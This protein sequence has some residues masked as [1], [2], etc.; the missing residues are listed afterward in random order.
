MNSKKYPIVIQ[1]FLIICILF[2]VVVVFTADWMFKIYAIVMFFVLLNS[3]T[4]SISNFHLGDYNDIYCILDM[5]EYASFAIMVLSAF[6]ENIPIFWLFSFIVQVLYIPWNA[7]YIKFSSLSPYNIR[8]IRQYSVLDGISASI[9]LIVF[10]VSIVT[11]VNPYYLLLGFASWLIVLGMWALDNFKFDSKLELP[12][13]KIVLYDARCNSW[14]TVKGIRVDKKGAIEEIKFGEVVAVP[15]ESTEYYMLPGLIDTHVHVDQNPYS[16]DISPLKDVYEIAVANAKEAAEAG[17]TTIVDM[18]GYQLNNYYITNKLMHANNEIS[19]IET[20]GCFFSKQYGHYMQHGGFVVATVSDASLYANYLAKLGIK[21]A[22]FMLGNYEIDDVALKNILKVG[23]TSDQR[24]NVILDEYFP[25]RPILS[26]DYDE[27]AF[28]KCID[29]LNS[30]KTYS[31]DELHSIVAEFKKKDIEVFAHAF[32][33]EDVIIA[34]EA[35]ITK[36]EHPGDYSDDLI[37]KMR[38]KN[39]IVTSSF[40]AAEDGAVLTAGLPQISVACSSELMDRWYQDTRKILPKLYD[41]GVKVAL[42]TDSGLSGTPCCSL[43]REI[44]SLVEELHIPPQKVIKSATI[45]A[46][47]KINANHGKH[48][49]ELVPKAPADFVLYESNFINNI[50]TLRHPAQVWIRGEKV[51]EKRYD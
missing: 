46:A 51:F 42:G 39:V 2:D 7:I 45:I 15:D 21:F 32:L 23:N 43:I 49:G 44:I 9:S 14:K 4:N 10:I 17:I 25:K 34:I 27:D 26:D 50:N 28:K 29:K 30:V 13:S 35:G 40:V 24:L 48:L 8:K 5:L 47:E 22:K 31:G 6:E 37:C 3:F 12:G 18:G 38:E 20:T 33:E 11:N 19:R 1:F 36:I 16:D 41:N